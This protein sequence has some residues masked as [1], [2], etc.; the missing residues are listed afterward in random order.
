M[1]NKKLLPL[2]CMY[3]YISQLY[4]I[5]HCYAYGARLCNAIIIINECIY[6]CEINVQGC[7]RL[8]ERSS[9]RI[10][11]HN[12]V[13]Y[14]SSISANYNHGCLN[15]YSKLVLRMSRSI[16]FVDWW[17]TQENLRYTKKIGEELYARISSTSNYILDH[18]LKLRVSIFL[19]IY[20]LLKKGTRE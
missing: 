5:I 14:W 8:R 13:I 6:T 19:Y 4:I 12:S 17:H 16:F 9:C 11:S 10:I 3:M 20:Y 7:K 15:F 2:I 1:I 18:I